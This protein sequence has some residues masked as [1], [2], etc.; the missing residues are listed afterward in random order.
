[1]RNFG[2][3]LTGALKKVVGYKLNNDDFVQ[4]PRPEVDTSIIP[5]YYDWIDS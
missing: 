2:A 1:V 3:Y 4:E 5:Y